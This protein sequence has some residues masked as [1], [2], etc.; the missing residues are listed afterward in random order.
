MKFFLSL[1]LFFS[2]SVKA[3]QA[4]QIKLVDVSLEAAAAY[5]SAVT[6]NAYVVNFDSEASISVQQEVLNSNQSHDLFVT[7]IESLN[8]QIV[9]SGDHSYIISKKVQSDDVVDSRSELLIETEDQIVERIFFSGR[10][11]LN[12]LRT[13]AE[14]IPEFKRIKI[15][16][17]D[18]SSKSAL[19]IGDK[20]LIFELKNVV[21]NLKPLASEKLTK[22][23]QTDHDIASQ[24]PNIEVENEKKS[25]TT[26]VSLDLNFADASELV[27]ALSLVLLNGESANGVKI[28][29]HASG[30]QLIL[31]GSED[32]VSAAIDVIQKLDRAPRQVYV[33]AIIAEVSEGTSKKL[34]LQFSIQ[35]DNVAG[36]VVTGVQTPNIGSLASDAFLAGATG[37]MIAIGNGAS[38]VPDIGLLLSALQ[39]DTD[40]R[41]L[42]TP[43]LMAAEN[44]ESVILV[45]QNV[46]F[47]TGQF[48]P[49]TGTGQGPFQTI[50]R[51][52]L[53]TKLKLKP[54]IGLKNDITL[55]VW[56]EVSR[57]DQNATG[58]TDV[59]TVKREITTVISAKH[60]ET[61]AIGGLRVEQEEMAISK[62]PFLGDIPGLGNLFRQET[63]NSVS[64]NLVIFLRP[65]LVSSEQQRENMLKVW[66]N[67]LGLDLFEYE[68]KKLMMSSPDPIGGRIQIETLRP[69][70]RPTGN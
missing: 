27:E 3:L 64:R 8:G 63:V 17:D 48:L 35:N 9:R 12:S 47:V 21:A 41:I 1:L 30:N 60:G 32:A 69:K 42:S 14:N 59:V 31:S 53:G 20:K 43:S 26:I 6:G 23:Q 24:R 2:F 37:G 49:E 10:I 46:P 22:T 13:M 38:R 33:D 19:L 15:V 55:E 52:D 18:N 58:L 51:E 39:G 66:K 34:G 50:K 25:I 11:S 7:L 5:F 4:D 65:R 40:N 54:R 29:A 70:V 28:S 68:E 45:G 16:P 57:I 36:S 67:D 62:V 56:Q 61:V 44:K